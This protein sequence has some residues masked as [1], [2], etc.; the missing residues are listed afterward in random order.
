M[1]ELVNVNKTFKAG[2]LT[3]EALKNIHLSIHE[4]EI[5]GIIGLSG[6]GK[7]TLVRTL[8]L[9]ERPDSGQV[10]YK[11]QDIL[12][13]STKD[14][15]HFRTKVGMIFQ[16]FNLFSAKDV[17]QNIAYPLQISKM[18]KK[19]I[20]IRVRELLQLVGLEDKIHAYPAQ[21]SGGQKQRVAIARALANHP[22]VLLCDEATSALDPKTTLSI[23]NLLKDLQAKLGLTVILIT[24]QMEVIKEICHRVAV[25]NGGEILEISSVE[26]LFSNPKSETAKSFIKDIPADEVVI[27]DFSIAHSFIHLKFIG[28]QAHSPVIYQL[29]KQFDIEVNIIS[30][31][32]RHL[33]STNVG[34]LIIGL[35]GDP[36]IILEAIDWL[37]SQ[38]IELEVL[39]NDRA[40]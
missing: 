5:F 39:T 11:D 25:M 34:D 36:Q 18:D 6:A 31:N 23:L 2:G 3:V 28:P 10:F 12:S 21:L 35:N 7:S 20:D 27:S 9:L 14:L 38:E 33:S 26:V 24:H 40:I 30:G 4:N 37:K 19:D 29:I 22:E 1:I 13:L 32:I 8:N 16:S 17:Y 15:C